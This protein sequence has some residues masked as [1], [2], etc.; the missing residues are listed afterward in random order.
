MVRTNS[1]G[2][3]D[4]R[5]FTEKKIVTTMSRLPLSGL[6][7]KMLKGHISFLGAEGRGGVVDKDA[8][9]VGQ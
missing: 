3:T 2:C 1:D 6:D 5:T 9:S 7:K 8:S 4:A